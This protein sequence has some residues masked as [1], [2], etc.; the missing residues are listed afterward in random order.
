MSETTMVEAT[1]R[2][3]RVKDGNGFVVEDSYGIAIL[4]T[5]SGAQNRRAARANARLI[6][7]AVNAYDA[8]VSALE[9]IHE[10]ADAHSDGAPD[11][12]PRDRDAAMIYAITSEALRLAREDA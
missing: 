12:S 1:P 4:S 6:V 7:R 2:P 3:W 11:A 8:L 10:W 5:T 9:Q